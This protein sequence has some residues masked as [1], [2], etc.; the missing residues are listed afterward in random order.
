LPKQPKQKRPIDEDEALEL[1][2]A[3][4]ARVDLYDRVL[5]SILR[6]RRQDSDLTARQLGSEIGM[7][8]SMINK[9]EALKKPMS[10]ARGLLWALKTNMEPA[11]LFESFL[12]GLR[13]AE[14][15]QARVQAREQA[16][17]RRRG[18]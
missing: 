2:A 15:E 4:H 3:D 11:E 5:M 7:S 18:S 16:V 13:Q 1:S 17:R 14:R 12:S 10:F 8:E 6:G 9:A